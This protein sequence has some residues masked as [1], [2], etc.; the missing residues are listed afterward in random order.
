MSSK[1]VKDFGVATIQEALKSD[2]KA[3][4]FIDA[5]GMDVTKDLDS[6]LISGGGTSAKDAKAL[7]VIRGRFD[8]TKIQDALKKQ[9]DKGDGLKLVKEGTTTLYEVTTGDQAMFGAI[10]DKGTMV[11]TLSKEATVDAVKNGGKKTT[12]LNKDM[13]KALSKFSAKESV[14]LAMVVNEDLKKMLGG[15][16][17]VGDSAGKLQTVTLALTVSDA[18]ALNVAGNT[19][20][21]E[22]AKALRSRL[23]TLVKVGA[24]LVEEN[25]ELAVLGEILKEVKVTSDKEAVTIALKV[26]KALIEKAMKGGA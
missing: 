4:A 6:V 14:S 24:A 15:I 3:K 1:L 7:I 10:V 9:A 23:S 26:T 5:T 22:S 2:E 25:K 20:E 18:I 13:K 16:P 19:G 21:E 17:Q 12:T 8:T 11:M